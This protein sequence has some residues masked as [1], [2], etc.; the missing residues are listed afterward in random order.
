MSRPIIV[1][2]TALLWCQ[3]AIAQPGA[4]GAGRN[5]PIRPLGPIIATSKDTLGPRIV[6]RG[7]SDGSVLVGVFAYGTPPDPGRRRVKLFDATLQHITPIS[8][9]TSMPQLIRYAGDTTL[10]LDQP[11][12]TIIVLDAKGK[13][14]RTMALPRQQDFPGLVGFIRTPWIDPQGRLIYQGTPQRPPLK[15]GQNP[16]LAQ[17]PFFPDSAPIVR[18]DFETRK[19]DTITKI[20]IAQP[21][22]VDAKEDNGNLVAKAILN[23]TSVSDEWTMLPDGTI[24]IVREH[25]YHIDWVT[26]DGK[27]TSTPKMPFDWKRITEE[28]KKVTLDSIKP[29]IDS[30]RQQ[31]PTQ[32]INMPDGGRITA[33]IDFQ[34]IAMDKMPDYEAPIGPGSVRADLDG[35]VWIVPRTTA[36]ST[37]GLLYDVVNR[38]GEIFERVQFPKG[39]ALVGFG[40]GGIVYLNTVVGNNGFLSVAKIR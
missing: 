8:D 37:G 20:R 31:N 36:A 10:A 16:I 11:S 9:S 12:R 2:A 5:I 35:N 25:D 6:T 21:G 23:P 27:M 28:Q 3:S 22:T 4:T 29:G 38:K 19:I 26:P 39:V 24:A 14:V 13:T 15:P 30:L 40:P 32:T 33:T 7:L 1:A 17:V 34:A 18:G